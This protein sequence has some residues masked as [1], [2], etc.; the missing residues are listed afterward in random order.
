MSALRFVACAFPILLTLAGLLSPSGAIAKH[1]EPGS[2]RLCDAR[3]CFAV[4]KP[5][6]VRAFGSF[7]YGDGP[8]AVARPPRFGAR[9][10]EVRFR[11]G[12]V[13]GIVGG[14]R[15]GRML[16]YGLNCGR[17]HRGSRYR[18]PAQVALEVRRLGAPLD[19]LH[20][21]HEVPRSC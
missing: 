10:I 6:A 4:T 2:L 12:F 9:A 3:Y 17:F 16:I 20:V 1:F 11:N 14:A 21:D 7:L 8:A 15:L 19:P 5:D 18:L 13:A